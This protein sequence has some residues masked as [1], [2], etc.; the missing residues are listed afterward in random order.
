[1]WRKR[2]GENQASAASACDF[3]ATYCIQGVQ[4]SKKI[5]AKT[6]PESVY[7]QMP[8]GIEGV[9]CFTLRRHLDRALAKATSPRAALAAEIPAWR[10]FT[11]L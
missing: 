2:P 8:S 9:A 10:I 5:I 11:G 6:A 4:F 3:S 7:V 1:M